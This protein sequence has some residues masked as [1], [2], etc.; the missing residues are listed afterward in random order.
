MQDRSRGNKNLHWAKRPRIIWRPENNQLSLSERGLPLACDN[1]T[2]PCPYYTCRYHL[3]FDVLENGNLKDNHPGRE[4]WEMDDTCALDV[5]E[6][7]PR[8]LE[9]VGFA[10]NL[11]RERVRQ[12]EVDAMARLREI[13]CDD[14]LLVALFV[15][16]DD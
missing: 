7:G 5:A 14:D 10:L 8:T 2:R 12:L 3:K 16:L 1:K 15:D 13:V 6:R 9:Q 4:Y 11:T